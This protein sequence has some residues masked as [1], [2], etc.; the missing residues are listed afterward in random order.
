[1]RSTNAT[2]TKQ[3]TNKTKTK[4]KKKLR[5]QIAGEVRW[6]NVIKVPE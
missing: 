6:K 5:G 3:K 2:T 4:K 1:V